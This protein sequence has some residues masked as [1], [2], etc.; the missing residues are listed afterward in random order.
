MTVSAPALAGF[1]PGEMFTTTDTPGVVARIA[2]DGST[3]QNP[4]ATLAGETG[5]VTGLYVDRT[6]IYGGDVIAVTTSGGIWRINS[7]GLAT[8]TALLG[9]ALSR[10]NNNPRCLWRSMVHGPERFS[11]ARKNSGP[12]LRRRR[13]GKRRHLHPGHQPRLTFVLIPAHENFYG[14]DPLSRK[15]WGAPGRRIR[16]H[17][18]RHPH[19]QTV[20]QAHARSLERN[21]HSKHTIS[22]R[23]VNG[24]RSHSRL[25]HRSDPWRQTSLRQPRRRPTRSRTQRRPRRRRALAAIGENI[26]MAGNSTIT[27]DLLVPGTPTVSIVDGHPSFGGVIE[28][29]ESTQPSNYQLNLSGNASLRFLMTRTDPMTLMAVALPP[30]PTGTRIVSLTQT[31]QSAGD[32]STLRDLSLS[33]NAG[34]VIV[35]PGT[36]GKFSASSRTAFVFGVANAAEPS[37]TISKSQ[38]F[39]RQRTATCRTGNPER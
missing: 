39:R 15:I 21:S 18:W 27:S 25:R 33:G 23:S 1:K 26:F 22:P 19:R 30:Q 3:V 38:P 31:S 36:Y 13:D 5:L 32:F 37:T 16:R 28:G 9:T 10:S 24:D 4:W 12:H 29:S 20:R 35:P 11:L 7:A 17:D 2:S 8:Q 34:A 6:G 14:V